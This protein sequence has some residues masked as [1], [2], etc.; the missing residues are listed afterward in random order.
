MSNVQAKIIVSFTAGIC[1]GGGVGYFVAQ[2]KLRAETEREI[3]GVKNL[4]RKLRDEDAKQAQEDWNPSE[5]V[6]QEED[7]DSVTTE[8]L[9]QEAARLGYMS[10]EDA[11]AT[12]GVDQN[13]IPPEP[14]TLVEEDPSEEYED[15]S[16]FRGIF[17]SPGDNP[18]DPRNWERDPDFPYVIT[19]EEYRIDFPEHEKLSITY[20]KGD[21][22]LSDERDQYIPDPDGTVL[23]SNLQFFGLASGDPRILHIRNER[24]GADFEVTLEDGAYSR[25]ILGFDIED[26]MVKESKQ[27]IR[28]MR[29][30]E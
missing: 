1:I 15:V 18:N 17:T 14:Q 10:W 6:D 3:E 4:Y 25:E 23:R 8:S 13:Y 12:L 20:Y 27:G 2:R 16:R 30:R 9:K 29:P 11:K 28:K 5:A 21:Q 7:L 19:D 22:T 26:A 24:V